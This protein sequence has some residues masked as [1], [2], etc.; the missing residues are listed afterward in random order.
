MPE[1]GAADPD[2]FV[3]AAVTLGNDPA[4]LGRLKAELKAN[5]ATASLFDTT[6]RVRQ[7]EAAFAEICRRQRARTT[8]ASFGL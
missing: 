2:A 7:L 6:S 4:A 1:L 8:P 5:R 3:K